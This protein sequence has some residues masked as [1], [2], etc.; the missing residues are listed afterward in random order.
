MLVIPDAWLERWQGRDVFDQLFAIDGRVYREREGRKTLRFTIDDKSY[1][2]KFH[3]GIG[4][5]EIIKDTLRLRLPVTSAKNEWQAIVRL[6][7]LGVNTARLVGYGKKGWN[8]ARYKSFVVMEE[9]TNSISLEDLCDEWQES[10]PGDALKR[11][12]IMEV[13]RIARI[14]HE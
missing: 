13:A 10:P 2:A 5:K 7:Q 12:L 9:L 4:W 3:R 14:L 1:F 8:P 11:A 6:N